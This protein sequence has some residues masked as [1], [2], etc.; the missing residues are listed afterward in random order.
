MLETICDLPRE[1]G[2]NA[3]KIDF[4]LLILIG[5]S[6]F[7]LSIFKKNFEDSLLSKSHC[8]VRSK[9]DVSSLSASREKPAPPL[10][11]TSCL[12][13]SMLDVCILLD[14]MSQIR[15][16][17]PYLSDRIFSIRSAA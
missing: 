3:E 8:K 4:L 16:E 6:F 2:P 1:K 13:V 12:I 15:F 14:R 17:S 11:H 7:P 10:T 5:K 9:P